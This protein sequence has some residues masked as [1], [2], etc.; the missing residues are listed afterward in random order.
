MTSAEARYRIGIDVGG[1]F[2]DF[3]FAETDT[4]RLTFHK[5]PSVPNDPSV[6]V[7]RG[8]AHFIAEAGIRPGQIELICHGT[9]IGLNAIIQ[10][11]GAR[12]A[13]VVS[14][15][16][17]DILE[18]ARLRLPSS[19]DFTEPRETPLIP[20]NHVYELAAR[21]TAKGEILAEPSEAE[22]DALAETLRAEGFDAVAINF[23]N[24]Y[25]DS[26][27]ERRIGDALRARL[28][29]VLIVESGVIWPESR[30]YERCLLVALNAFIRPMMTQYFDRLTE[31][32][33]GLGVGCPIYITANNGGTLSLDTAK[34]R[35]ID[36][37][38]SGPAS[39]VVAATRVARAA[40][41]RQI[42]TFDMGGTSADISLSHTGEPDFTASTFVGDFP[43]M[44]PVVN[45][46]AIGAGGGSIIWV[47]A[48][49]ILKVGPLSAGADPGPACYGR[50]GTE[51]TV[52]DCYVA[53]GIIDPATFLDG[54]MTLDAAAA[55][56][57]L[58]V[59][60][61][62]LGFEGEHRAA[63]AAEAALRVATAKMGTE[64]VKLLAHAGADMRDYTLLG[65]GGAGATHACMLADEAQLSSVLV[66]TAPG[67]FCALG[68][69]LADVRRDYVRTAR[70]RFAGPRGE[71][72][73][74]AIKGTLAEMEEQAQ[75]WILLEGDLV[76]EHRFEVTFRLRYPSQAYELEIS[77]PEDRRADM[78]AAE[79]AELFHAEHEKLYGFSERGSELVTSTLRL[80]VIGSV[81]SGE[82]P[83]APPAGA[84]PRARRI[85]RWRGADIDAAV[86]GRADL[87]HGSAFDGPAI[88]EQ[89]DTTTFVLPGWRAEADR[90]GTL[91]LTRIPQS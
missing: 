32:V 88:I 74:N 40:E 6:A 61:A 84:E 86:F 73:W 68:A 14:K 27:L 60:A 51:A 23:L 89:P 13:L 33:A 78:S 82:L 20:R 49:G 12:T 31:R 44:M 48:Q 35:P 77:I 37:I 38:L 41:R 75:A 11:R 43:I 2:T 69:I 3:V 36:T 66:P 54:K 18:I 58:E 83:D 30:E 4:N 22:I 45:I 25:S 46:L 87:G 80:A 28:P 71:A 9:T 24:A 15:G 56:E 16:N 42:V 62:K 1:T 67:T 19:Y 53:L 39:G 85:V 55:T 21:M 50:G 52:T 64:I 81:G 76:G 8:I 70:H 90:I 57:A 59:I 7:E 26:S 34:S 72:G 65:F 91:H 63:A 47:D 5:Q 10:R 29:G 17:R 79:A